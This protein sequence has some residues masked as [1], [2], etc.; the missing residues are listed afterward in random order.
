[1]ARTKTP[2]LTAAQKAWQTRKA[3]EA[4]AIKAK[5]DAKAKRASR[6]AA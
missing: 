6:K 3:N 2:Q 5:A 1:M 4:A